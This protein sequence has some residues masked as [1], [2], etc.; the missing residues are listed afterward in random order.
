MKPMV[1]CL[2]PSRR[3]A[4]C[5]EDGAEGLGVGVLHVYGKLWEEG[6]TVQKEKM[7]KKKSHGSEGCD[8]ATGLS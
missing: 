3:M 7:M 8:L 5:G 6:G 1:D 4:D 2:L